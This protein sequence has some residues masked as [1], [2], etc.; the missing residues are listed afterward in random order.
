MLAGRY[1]TRATVNMLERLGHR[2]EVFDP[3]YSMEGVRA[4]LLRM[5]Q[6]LGRVDVAEALVAAFDADLAA[7]RSEIGDRP[8]AALYYA[9]GYTSGDRTLAGHILAAAGFDN[10]AMEA[11]LEVSGVLPLERL[12]MAQ[13]DIVISGRRYRGASRAEELLDH[14]ALRA[15]TA[16]LPVSVLSDRDWVCGTPHVLRAVAGLVEARR[17]MEAAQ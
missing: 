2:I 16:G 1:T 15:L 7:L 9:N 13:P 12:V 10:V 14:P 11:G 6:V 8:R 3:E 17:A 5:G 4:N